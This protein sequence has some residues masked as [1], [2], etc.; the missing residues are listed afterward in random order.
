MNSKS[1]GKRFKLE[2]RGLGL[3]CVDGKSNPL[4]VPA[5]ATIEIIS[6]PTREEGIVNVLWEGRELAMFLF[7]IDRAGKEI[8]EQSPSPES[9]RW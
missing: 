9:F 5:G 1:F 7:D 8:V 2:K 3:D 4:F 6:D